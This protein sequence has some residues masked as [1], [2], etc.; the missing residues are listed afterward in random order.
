[1]NIDLP[2]PAS[3][4]VVVAHP[5]DA[6]FQCGATLAKWANSGTEVSYLICTD[7]SKGTWNPNCDQNQLIQDREI[8]QRNAA[9]SLGATGQIVFLGHTDGELSSDL[10]TR[11]QVAFVIRNIQPNVI[12]GH[13][14]WKRYRLHPDH[15]H[16]GLL[17]VEGIVG[18]RDPFFFREHGLAP[19][20]PDALLLHKAKVDALLQHKSQFE[21]T[22]KINGDDDAS[23]IAKFS[24][25]IA[26]DLKRNG[27][28]CDLE[29]AELFKLI[30]AL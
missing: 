23:A 22:H 3:A 25:S 26:S 20:R 24:A 2:A 7:G 18:A 28:M 29:A 15:R 19:H 13:D 14:P 17:A 21:T 10:E 12:L 5:D 30:T 4:L 27:S 9:Q 6:E 11:S 8:E 16:A 1:M